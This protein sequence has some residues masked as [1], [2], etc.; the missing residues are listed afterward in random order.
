MSRVT[1]RPNASRAVYPNSRSAPAF[2]LVMTP[3]RSLLT[4]ASSDDS[5]I[6]ASLA[7]PSSASLRAVMS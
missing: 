5:T 7:R 6:A 1:G 4:M 3:L 2:Q